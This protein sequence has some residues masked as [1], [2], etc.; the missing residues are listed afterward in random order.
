MPSDNVFEEYEKHSKVNWQDLINL[1]KGFYQEVK[2][3]RQIVNDQRPVLFNGECS[4]PLIGW[5]KYGKS[6]VRENDVERLIIVDR[7]PFYLESRKIWCFY[8]K[9]TNEFECFNY[10]VGNY[11]TV[12]SSWVDQNRYD[13]VSPASEGGY[14][15]ALPIGG[16]DTPENATRV[17]CETAL[18]WARS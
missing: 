7:S 2:F 12:P 13:R 10:Y 15:D 9:H 6:F 4:C 8:G 16:W 3:L 14:H 1:T 17:M 11:T 5:I 18:K